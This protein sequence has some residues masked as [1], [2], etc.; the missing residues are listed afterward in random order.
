MFEQVLLAV[1]GRITAAES[2]LHGLEHWRR[3][4]NNG[5]E[6]AAETE[7]ADRDVIEAFCGPPRFLPSQR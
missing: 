6:L 5:I 7:G 1:L 3:V 2:L 4:A